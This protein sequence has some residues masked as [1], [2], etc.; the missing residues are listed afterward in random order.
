MRVERRRAWGWVAVSAAGVL[1]LLV[2]VAVREAYLSI[3]AGLPTFVGAC[4]R[5]RQ[6]GLP[7][8]P[9]DQIC[10]P[11]FWEGYRIALSRATFLQATG[12]WL[13]GAILVA[14]GRR[15]AALLVPSVWVLFEWGRSVGLESGFFRGIGGTYPPEWRTGGL[16]TFTALVLVL[17]P[18]L[19]ALGVFPR[20]GRE[21]LTARWP[22]RVAALV[23]LIV[24]TL[25]L[26][27]VVGRFWVAWPL[28]IEDVRTPLW[29]EIVAPATAGALIVFGLL[30]G[31]ARGWWPWSLAVVSL[32]LSGGPT[33]Q[34]L[35]P[36]ESAA[37]PRS[38]LLFGAVLPLFLLGIL[39]SLH[40]D[41]VALLDRRSWRDR[42]PAGT[43]RRGWF[44]AA[45]VLAA[46]VL[47]ASVVAFRHDP[48]I[49][50]LPTFIGKRSLANDVAA[51]M[52]LMDA[53]GAAKDYRREHG[54]FEGFRAWDGVARV[55][56]VAWRDR[57]PLIGD[58]YGDQYG[59][60]VLPMGSDEVRLVEVSRSGQAWCLHLD[61]RRVTYG[62]SGPQPHT[63][64][65]GAL[66]RKAI[67]NCDQA[68]WSDAA[69]EPP[70]LPTC[71][72]ADGY[73]ICRM[74]TVLMHNILTRSERPETFSYAFGD[75]WM[76]DVG[77]DDHVRESR[78]NGHPQVTVWAG[79]GSGRY[80]LTVTALGRAER[81][82]LGY[83][84]TPWWIA[85]PSQRWETV[86]PADVA[87]SWRT[88]L[89]GRAYRLSVFIGRRVPIEPRR[90]LV[91]TINSI[92]PI[93]TEMPE[94]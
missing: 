5:L 21:R 88:A 55:P 2:W 53:L 3:G 4:E 23:I 81:S 80:A 24:A 45:N 71:D 37:M 39:W 40:T 86:P 50:E 73:L 31:R 69:L 70:P 6:S 33:V 48:W 58:P 8:L 20:V 1:S 79:D 60:A 52:D 49:Y 51:R 90:A 32:L 89:A 46:G 75:R 36:I 44:V 43:A 13:A 72:P 28:P 7:L 54:T 38:T 16:V 11:S 18:V 64:E 57:P 30:L 17:V 26:A 22:A 41:L 56:G 77:V 91:R 14:A 9:T 47:V 67:A 82:E 42:V 19:V 35:V 12:A 94:A 68:P 63:M 74:V 59:V 83:Q 66:V 25:G 61:H 78:A 87:Y 62:G 84:Q 29:A 34:L 85:D 27:L 15:W 10:F 92:R 93:A 76:A 65:Q